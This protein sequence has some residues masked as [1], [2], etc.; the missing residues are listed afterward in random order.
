M[1]Y[2]SGRVVHMCSVYRM[3]AIGWVFVLL[4]NMAS[5]SCKHLNMTKF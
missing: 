2:I 5:Y 1:A 3:N 4:L